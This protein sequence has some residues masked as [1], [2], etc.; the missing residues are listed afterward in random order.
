MV[1]DEEGVQ[2]RGR[3]ALF[4]GAQL[5]TGGHGHKQAQEAAMNLRKTFL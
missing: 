1:E 4:S 5:N 2:G 3:Q